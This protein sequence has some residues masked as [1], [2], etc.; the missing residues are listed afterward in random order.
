M[1]LRKFRSGALRNKCSSPLLF[2]SETYFII[3]YTTIMS[4]RE[5]GRPAEMV[6]A[7]VIVGSVPSPNM[8]GDFN[9]R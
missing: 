3:M 5:K 6:P 1:A 4:E 9:I 8:G 2:G 7:I